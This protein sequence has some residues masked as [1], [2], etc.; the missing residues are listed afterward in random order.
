MPKQK[1]NRTKKTDT[2][3]GDEMVLK[4]LGAMRDDL[5][6][7]PLPE[8]PTVEQ[9]LQHALVLFQSEESALNWLRT[10][11]PAL[12]K[13]PAAYMN[14]PTGREHVLRVLFGAYHGTYQ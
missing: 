2:L 13:T 4:D 6:L 11:C 8:K 9:V 10:H 3:F 7:H 1:M 14:T 12:G 5:F